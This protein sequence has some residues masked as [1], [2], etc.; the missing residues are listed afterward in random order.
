MSMIVRSS[1][2]EPGYRDTN[3]YQLPGQ[4]WVNHNDEYPRLLRS[5]T[6]ELIN[7]AGRRR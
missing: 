7:V 1:I 4:T 5:R 6:V 2:P 3:I